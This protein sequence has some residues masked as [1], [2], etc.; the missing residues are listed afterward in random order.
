MARAGW[1]AALSVGAVMVG[2]VAVYAQSGSDPT[3]VERVIDGDTVDVRIDGETERI[4]LLNVDTPET[5]HPEK[6][7]ECL[8]PEATDFLK[9]QLPAGHEIELEFDE[10]RTDRYGRVLAGIFKDDELINAEIARAGLGVAASFEPNTRFY[11]EVKSAQDEAESQGLGLFDE[12][13]DCTIAALM[14]A[15]EEQVAALPEELAD[16]V[17]GIEE[18]LLV[19]LAAAEAVSAAQASLDVFAEFPNAGISRGFSDRSE[20]LKK[21]LRTHA[22]KLEGLETD[23][24][25]RIDSIKE[26]ER[27]EEER[28]EEERLEEEREEAERQAEEREAERAAEREA[29]RQRQAEQ[30]PAP[31]PQPAP[32]TQPAP[33]PSPQP[34]QAPQPA[35]EKTKAPQ[36]PAPAPSRS[37][38]NEGGGGGTPNLGPEERPPGA[39]GKNEAPP[40]YT[41]PRCFLPGGKWWNPC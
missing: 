3:T 11:P 24:E 7:I 33:E 13:Q 9:E 23:A 15:A 41:G 17:S 8:G 26:E 22:D 31:Q 35:P 28:L 29:E 27:L 2:G 12:S 38:R 32:T 18:Q 16:D 10:E 37:N 34:T 14:S 19:I 40:G 5:K 25:E 4:R 6:E 1:I 20:E 36:P 21:T 39:F 30:N